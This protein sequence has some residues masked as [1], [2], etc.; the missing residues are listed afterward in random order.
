MKFIQD[1]INAARF[2]LQDRQAGSYRY[3]DNDLV[4]GLAI[5]FD[6]AYRIRPDIFI[7]VDEPAI[8]DQPLLTTEVPVPRGYQMAFVFYMCGYVSLSDQ[9]DTQDARAAVFL[10]KFVSQLTTTPS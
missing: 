7:R 5:A 2:Q 6:E 10:N 1:Y 4:Q 9:E 8:V 3:A